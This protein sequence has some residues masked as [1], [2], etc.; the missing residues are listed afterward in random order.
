MQYRYKNFGIVSPVFLKGFEK[1]YAWYKYN[2]DIVK[3]QK[4]DNS[5]KEYGFTIATLSWNKENEC[6]E[7]TSCGLRYLQEREDNLEKWLYAFCKMKEI[8]FEEEKI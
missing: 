8:E 6:F 3:Y 7:F 2:F 5:D 4:E 1:L